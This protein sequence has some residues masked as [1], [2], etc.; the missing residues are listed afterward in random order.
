MFFYGKF[1]HQTTIRSICGGDGAAVELDGVFYDG[2]TEACT[3][4][5]AGATLVHTIESLKEVWQVFLFNT[6]TIILK[7]DAAQLLIVFK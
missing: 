2:K 7:A 5:L 3:A 6:L 1:K 4:L